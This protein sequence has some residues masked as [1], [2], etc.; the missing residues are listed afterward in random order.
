MTS[1]QILLRLRLPLSMDMIMAGIRTAITINIG[2]ATVAAF[3][4]AGG[5]GE[6][7]IT[8]ITLNDNT[9]ILSGAIPAALLALIAD[10]GMAWIESR[11]SW[12][13][14]G[15]VDAESSGWWV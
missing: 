7:I 4:G 14:G 15:V 1:R 2:T 9:M 6:S 13:L 11:M 5:L 10:Q 3:I 8:G 12:R